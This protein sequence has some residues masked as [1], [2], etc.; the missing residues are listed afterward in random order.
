[1]KRLV[2]LLTLV[3]AM[4]SCSSWIENFKKDPVSQVQQVVSTVETV[5]E[6]AKIVFGQVKNAIPPE[7]QPEVQ[8]KFDQLILVVQNAKSVLQ[9]AVA[10]AA[11]AKNENP[12]LVML[13]ANAMKAVDDLQAFIESSKTLMSATQGA[14]ASKGSGVLYGDADLKAAVSRMKRTQG[15]PKK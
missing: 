8:T 2:G 15:T 6:I 4:T 11:E 12:D 1:M 10:A 14:G 5:V 9:D 3:L 7:K 13:I